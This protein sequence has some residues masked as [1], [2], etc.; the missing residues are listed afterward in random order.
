M[1]LINMVMNDDTWYVVRNTRGVTGFVGYM[2]AINLISA[3][4]SAIQTRKILKNKAHGIWN[5]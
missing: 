3:V 5:A 1:F 4:C 2:F